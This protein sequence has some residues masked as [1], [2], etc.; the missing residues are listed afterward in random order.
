MLLAVRPSEGE[1]KGIF[2]IG[3]GFKVGVG[4]LYIVFGEGN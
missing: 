1:L 3:N 4:V 2:V